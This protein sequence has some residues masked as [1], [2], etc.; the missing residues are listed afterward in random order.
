MSDILI[1]LIAVAIGVLFSFAGIVAMR[2]VITVWGA[3]AG[4]NV[5]AAIV[6][7]ITGDPMFSG[8]LGWI[9]GIAVAL[10]F[11]M[12][13][14]LCYAVAIT[15]VMAS[16]GFAIGS[17]V[18]TALGVTWNWVIILVGVCVGLLLA[19]AALAVN[20]PAILLIVVSAF[21]GATVTVGGLML[22][23]STIDLPDLSRAEV[24]RHIGDDWWWYVIY[25]TLVIFGVVVQS[26]LV[27]QD[28]DT[29][30]RW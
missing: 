22:L 28:S 29:G 12:L 7:G 3:F 9:V 10:L 25:L 23:T 17:A 27:A 1:G 16:V 5:G 30:Q 21:G 8:A 18:T 14:Y 15:L 2:A 13:A 6:S 11:A 20:L 4:L 19:V 26:R 24:T